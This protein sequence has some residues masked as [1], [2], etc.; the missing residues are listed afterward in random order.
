MISEKNTHNKRS[1]FLGASAIAFGAYLVFSVAFQAFADP[2]ASPY[3]P[4][5]TLNPGCNPTSTNCTV[6]P[7][8][9]STT[10]L[11]QNGVL[12]MSDSSGTVSANA[13][14]L[15]FTSSTGR[16]GIGT[17][18]PLSELSVAGLS[19]Q[20]TTSTLVLLG[21]TFIT[22]GNPSGTL[23]GANMSTSYNGDF[24]NFQVNSTSILDVTSG[25]VNVDNGT[26][27]VNTIT[28]QVGIGTSQP[29]SSLQVVGTV[30]ATTVSSTGLT[31]LNATSSG[32]LLIGNIS[33]TNEQPSGYLTVGGQATFGNVSST[34]NSLTGYLQLLGGPSFSTSTALLSLGSSTQGLP[35]ASGT[36]IGINTSSSFG[37][38]FLVFQNNSTTKFSV[39]S[40]GA[41]SI[42]GLLNTSGT[43][44]FQVTST[45]L[46]NLLIAIGPT[47]N[48]STPLINLG[49]STQNLPSAL[50]TYIGINTTSSFNGDFLA[51]EV[52]SSTKFRV[53]SSGRMALATG[54]FF[55]STT[56]LTVCALSNCTTPTTASATNAVAFFASTAGTTTSTSI[57]ARGAITSGLTDIGEYITVAGQDSDYGQGDV[58]SVSTSSDDTF[59]KSSVPYDPDLAGAITITAG[60]IAGGGEDGH[61]SNVI[62]LAG[63]IPV[64]VTGEDGP[65]AIGDFITSSDVVGYGMKATQP[66]EV[67]GTAMGSF[68]GTTVND[69]GTVLVFINPHYETGNQSM[70]QEIT[71]YVQE[72]LQNLGVVIVDGV[73][74]LK[75]IVVDKV[76]TNVLCVQNVCVTSDQL[77]ALLQSAGITGG[78]G[79]TSTGPDIGTSTDSTAPTSTVTDT[80]TDTSVSSSDPSSDPTSTQPVA[81]P[82]APAPDPDASSTAGAGS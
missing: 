55:G 41:T 7:P 79:G 40:S 4:G 31:F 3:I 46:G 11:P 76:T 12:F 16:F 37:G 56:T 69:T 33:S 57:V 1:W 27:F 15:S 74:T 39:A 53:A 62:A 18:S 61:G 48:S 47:Q 65:I 25:T 35:N 29:S 14:Q 67:V 34:N 26:L 54:T 8:L 58:L 21:N 70:L 45:F 23:I 63:R 52:N 30:M 43:A 9:F 2:P 24:L 20:S 49:S 36:F 32:N 42:G 44:T 17:S 22:G 50:G 68:D 73:A 82:P 64:K 77:G 81:D 71:Q 51:F 72:A 6:L 78:G 60:L 13:A 66:G 38:F 59:Q 28:N 75:G 80:E 10:T 19:P 5:E